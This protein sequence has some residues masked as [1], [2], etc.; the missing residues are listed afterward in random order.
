M[1]Q[2]T[3][4]PMTRFKVMTQWLATLNCCQSSKNWIRVWTAYRSRTILIIFGSLFTRFRTYKIHTI[5]WNIIFGTFYNIVYTDKYLYCNYHFPTDLAQNGTPLV[6][7]ESEK[8]ITIQIWFDLTR[9]RKYFSMSRY[10]MTSACDGHPRVKHFWPNSGI[11]HFLEQKFLF[12]TFSNRYSYF[13][14][15]RTNIL[16]SHLL[17][18]IFLFP[19]FSNKNSYFLLFRTKILISYF[20]EQKFS[21]PSF[22]NKYRTPTFFFILACI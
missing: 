11:S 14:L 7:N 6:P 2:F 16:I 22:S 18:R 5:I 10:K 17:E 12:P 4:I 21:F 15:F 20:F 9:S 8:G 1:C 3:G 13:P 19:T